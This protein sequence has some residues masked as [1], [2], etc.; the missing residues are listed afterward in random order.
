M[1]LNRI[2][3][4]ALFL[5]SVAGLKAQTTA[6]TFTPSHLKAAEQYLVATGINAQFG[7]ITLNM[8]NSSSA[9]MPEEHRASY[10][11]V[12]QAFMAKY[13][14]WDVLKD[15][16]AKIYA[17][18]FTEDE[19]KQLTVF[20]NSP[21]GKKVSL[22]TPLL[23]QKGMAMGQQVVTDHR[24]ELEQMMKDAFQADTATATPKSN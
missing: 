9:Q 1:K 3:L 16:F 19:L 7:D 23:M 14:T 18:E 24:P 20:Y 12:M 11:K 5:F 17:A 8:I 2:I 13:Y 10:V 15:N 6:P 4:I 21:I 22:K